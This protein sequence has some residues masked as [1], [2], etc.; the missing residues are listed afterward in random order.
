[1]NQPQ[2]INESYDKVAEKYANKFL[3]E[4][5][6]KPFDRAYLKHFYEVNQFQ[7]KILDLGC[8]PGQ[9]TKFLYD[10]GCRD[11]IG[12]DLS[13]NMIAVARQQFPL[14]NF[15]MGNMLHLDFPDNSIGSITA[16]Y[17][18]V[19]FNIIE[20]EQAFKEAHRVLREN[21]QFFFSFHATSTPD[22][23]VHLK[24][25]LEETVDMT[26]Y[27]FE[28]DSTIQLLRKV[29]FNIVDVI[30]RYPYS[31]EHPS[32]RAYIVAQKQSTPHK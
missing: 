22:H 12:V 32:Q 1:M 7:G 26:F 18:I 10:C 16:F 27:F 4:L 30:V 15:A 14:I 2:S 6:H 17:S 9:T 21:G 13:S 19:N 8:G 28:V 24:E 31:Q 20:L 3:E 25:F 11:L 29:G 23:K 5:D